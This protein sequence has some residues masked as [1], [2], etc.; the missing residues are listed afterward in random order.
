VGDGP[1]ERAIGG[2]VLE[3]QSVRGGVHDVVHGHHF[4][5]GGALDDGLESLATDAAEA[6]DADTDGHCL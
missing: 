1:V 3:E 4:K 5:L 2:V 6:V